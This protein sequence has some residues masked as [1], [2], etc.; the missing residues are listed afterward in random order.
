MPND[1]RGA[2][3]A[4]ESYDE[5]IKSKYIN[6]LSQYFHK[7]NQKYELVEFSSKIR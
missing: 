5:Q 6:L 3:I 7:T 2:F 4:I 1:D